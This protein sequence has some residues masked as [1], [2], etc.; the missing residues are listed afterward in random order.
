MCSMN[1][2]LTDSLASWLD[3]KEKN[4]IKCQ[5]I[6]YILSIGWS[7]GESCS[8]TECYQ[9]RAVLV[10]LQVG[11][12]L[13]ITLRWCC[14]WRRRQWHNKFDTTPR[15]CGER[16]KKNLFAHFCSTTANGSE[17]LWTHPQGKSKTWFDFVVL[18]SNV[19]NNCRSL[20][21]LI[22]TVVHVKLFSMHSL[23]N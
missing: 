6:C 7:K 20:C 23:Y 15:R 14:K 5:W 9:S 19:Y 1:F 21:S 17:E 3:D 18:Y 11:A 10:W 8:N 16:G 2:T 4:W 13:S 22:Q 12:A